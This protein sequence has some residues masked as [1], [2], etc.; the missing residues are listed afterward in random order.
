MSLRDQLIRS[1]LSSSTLASSDRQRA[2]D[3]D[4]SESEEDLLAEGDRVLGTPGAKPGSGAHARLLR[5]ASPHQSALT[6][7]LLRQLNQRYGNR[8]VNR[9]LK[10]ARSAPSET[11][12]YGHDVVGAPDDR[13]E[14]EAER[15]A[16]R[17]TGALQQ[18]GDTGQGGRAEG[19]ASAPRGASA[20]AQGGGQA[21]PEPLRQSAERAFGAD[22]AAVRVHT[23][24]AAASRSEDLQARAFTKNSDL[25]FA[26]G[27][28][29]PHTPGGQ[30]LLAHE[31]AHVVQQTGSAAERAR[32]GVSAADGGVIQRR[33]RGMAANLKEE[34]GDVSKKAKAKGAIT[35]GRGKST[36]AQ[37]IEALERYEAEEEQ[38]ANS[39][40]WE[41]A[42]HYVEM[43]YTILNLIQ[44]WF[45]SNSRADGGL[46]PDDA[47]RGSALGTLRSLVA[48]EVT[49]VS[50]L[51]GPDVP[52]VR[53]DYG[54]RY[55]EQSVP[56]QLEGPSPEATPEPRGA[57]GGGRL[58]PPRQAPPPRPKPKPKP[59][60]KPRDLPPPTRGAQAEALTSS[61]RPTKPRPL[62]RQRAKPSP[63]GS[64]G[65]GRSL[66][67]AELRL[68]VARQ[69]GVRGDRT[70]V[71]YATIDIPASQR[72]PENDDARQRRRIALEKR[73]ADVNR[74]IA[75]AQRS[76]ATAERDISAY[77]DRPDE[78]PIVETVE[79]SVDLNL[80]ASELK[81]R[82]L[83][84]YSD[85]DEIDD[86]FEAL[87]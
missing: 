47:A 26:P 53:E 55:E 59:K 84:L 67:Y 73:R 41:S 83:A 11:G 71:D 33:L 22:F 82:I 4:R 72:R 45:A 13:Y 64:R 36:Y 38:V 21:L 5:D 28:Y 60:P 49:T 19:P 2:E 29:A 57:E 24:A 56:H 40:E 80:W 51:G 16:A 65:E 10:T 48:T 30:A 20:N 63:T 66:N 9:V 37:I 62:P 76:L 77:D 34:A 44:H 31:L 8:Y 35:F 12:L 54:R 68:P 3:S 86:A 15:V 32:A 74:R 81:K 58:P 52:P 6:Q 87:Q 75:E 43:L 1:G 78:Y 7:G 46:R 17:L 27:E 23:D 79:G 85:L 39:G 25:F 70:S 18:S 61:P 42:E 50:R 14:R 69:A